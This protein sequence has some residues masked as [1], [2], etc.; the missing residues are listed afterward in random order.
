MSSSDQTN[1]SGSD[2]PAISANRYRTPSATLMIVIG[3]NLIYRTI[4]ASKDP[5]SR[6]IL[7]RPESCHG[8]ESVGIE[9]ISSLHQKTAASNST[10]TL[11]AP[12]LTQRSG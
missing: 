1:Q 7:A 5:S 12:W 10:W 3:V 9:S 8:G 11:M 2:P 6:S 4:G